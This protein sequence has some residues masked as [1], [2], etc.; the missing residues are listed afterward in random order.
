MKFVFVAVAER[1]EQ[2]GEPEQM[3]RPLLVAVT[4]GVLRTVTDLSRCQRSS[5]YHH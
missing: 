5:K 2:F 1:Q 4:R 3:E